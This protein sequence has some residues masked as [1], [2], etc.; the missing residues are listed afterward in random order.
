MRIPGKSFMGEMSSIVPRKKCRWLILFLGFK[1]CARLFPLRRCGVFQASLL[2]E[3][4][5]PAVQVLVVRRGINFVGDDLQGVVP[6]TLLG[7][8]GGSI[9]AFGDA[10]RGGKFG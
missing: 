6:E 2:Q 4:S 7:V 5:P 3:G 9:H 8:E 1:E 10:Q